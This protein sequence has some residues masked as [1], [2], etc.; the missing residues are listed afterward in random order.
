MDQ[1]NALML[2]RLALQGIAGALTARGIGDDSLW[3][4]V[5]GLATH[6]A[7]GFWSWRATQQLRAQASTGTTALDLAREMVG[8]R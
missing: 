6:A 2:L 7:G 5:I 1:G 8:R 4:L 3:E